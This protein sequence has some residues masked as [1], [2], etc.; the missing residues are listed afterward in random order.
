MA[1]SI[2]HLECL[3]KK[4]KTTLSS[5]TIRGKLRHSNQNISSRLLEED[6]WMTLA[7]F[8][9]TLAYTKN[10]GIT[11]T[12]KPASFPIIYLFALATLKKKKSVKQN[13][14]CS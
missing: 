2:K 4:T 9:I 12:I 6:K 10:A 1:G 13:K 7:M 3:N 11:A 5:Q 8:S 14:S